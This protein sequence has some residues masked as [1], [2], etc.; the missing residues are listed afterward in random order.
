M[1]DTRVRTL[2]MTR[3]GTYYYQQSA[4]FQ[5]VYVADLDPQT[6]KAIGEPKRITQR[7][8]M[9]SP[10]WSP[11]GQYLAYHAHLEGVFTM[12]KLRLLI[13]S[14][15][16]SEEVVVSPKPAAELSWRRPQWHPD[17]RSLIIGVAGERA[18]QIDVA[19]GEHKPFL[20][21]VALGRTQ[22]LPPDLKTVFSVDHDEKAKE[23]RIYRRDL[24]SGETKEL[25]RSTA[26]LVF[27]LAISNDGRQLA[28]IERRGT[29]DW[30]VMTIPAGGGQ[31]RELYHAKPPQ[32]I[33]WSLPEKAVWSADGRFLMFMLGNAKGEE[34]WAV[35]AS[36]GAAF[37]VGVPGQ[38]ATPDVRPDGRQLAFTYSENR[39]ELWALKNL[40]SPAKASK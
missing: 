25:W 30:F 38:P 3:D 39:S 27:S 19:S 5:D 29:S 1:G 23:Y 8:A 32:T 16:T 22:R 13:R 31:P 34:I 21:S 40:L 35:P 37:P 33:F 9:Y 24:E 15:K 10:M 17:G 18:R 7:G 4:Y 36:G 6:C 14:M 26:S 28:F 20:E 12:E 2:G 11:D